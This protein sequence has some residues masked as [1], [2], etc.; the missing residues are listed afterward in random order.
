MDPEKIAIVLRQTTYTETEARERL[1]EQDWDSEKVIRLYLCGE[2]LQQ[3]ATKA[4]PSL[5]QMMF[6]E[7]RHYMDSNSKLA[8]SGGLLNK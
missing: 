5:N 8:S 6:T 4:K 7:I 1:E 3:E 2:P